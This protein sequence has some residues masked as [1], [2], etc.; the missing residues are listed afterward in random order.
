LLAVELWRRS[1]GD[2]DGDWGDED[3]EVVGGDAEEEAR[4]E[5]RCDA[6]EV[7]AEAGEGAVA[8]DSTVDTGTTAPFFESLETENDR[9]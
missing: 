9:C 3:D 6:L 7:A 4:S 2:E 8:V 1:P 5:E